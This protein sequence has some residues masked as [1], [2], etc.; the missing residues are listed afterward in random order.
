ML[1]GSKIDQEGKE[2]EQNDLNCSLQGSKI[3]PCMERKQTNFLQ[4]SFRS[5]MRSIASDLQKKMIPMDT[6]L[7]LGKADSSNQKDRVSNF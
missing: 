6:E 7:A 5:G 1:L 4:R 3:R 2:S